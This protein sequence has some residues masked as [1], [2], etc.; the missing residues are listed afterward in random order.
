MKSASEVEYLEKKKNNIVM[1]K[2]SMAR[3]YV[4]L[5]KTTLLCSKRGSKLCDFIQ[6]LMQRLF[7]H[8][9]N[10]IRNW[11][12]SFNTRLF[13]LFCFV[14]FCFLTDR[15]HCTADGKKPKTKKKTKMQTEECLG[16]N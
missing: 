6:N 5:S 1:F 3:S 8:S 4:I 13:V 16:K 11:H 10:L 9:D 7:S 15:N 12:T 14:L 2:T